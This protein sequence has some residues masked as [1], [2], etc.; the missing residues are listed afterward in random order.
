MTNLK[1]ETL[2]ALKEN[3]KTPEDVLWI[4]DETC[5]LPLNS[6]WDMADREYDDSYGCPEVNMDLLVVGSDWWLE[7]H[8]YDGS[9]W[10][11]FKTLPKMPNKVGPDV[12][13]F[14]WE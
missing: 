7:R 12:A 6:F 8:E 9:E 3:N 11:E 5:R 10:W 13:V 14:K 1:N 2:N 4:G